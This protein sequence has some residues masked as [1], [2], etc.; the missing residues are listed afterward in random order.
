MNRQSMTKKMMLLMPMAALFIL[1]ASIVI[2]VPNVELNPIQP[3]P[4][5]EVDFTVTISN[6]DNIEKV[7]IRVQ[8]CGNEPNIGYICYADE[9]NVTMIETTENVYTASVKL[10]HENAIEMKYQIKYLVDQEWVNY[11]DEP[12]TIDLDTSGQS[13]DNNN[14]GSSTKTPGFELIGLIVSISFIIFI[15]YRIKR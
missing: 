8:E 12:V 2:A 10:S 11:P 9:S 1:I 15:L 13:D 3:K 14:G 6:V 7:T 4:E 5:E